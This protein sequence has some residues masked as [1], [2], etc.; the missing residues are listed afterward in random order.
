MLKSS[1]AGVFRSHRQIGE[2]ILAGQEFGR[3]DGQPISA[4]LSCIIRGLLMPGTWVPAGTK[5]GLPIPGRREYCYTISD[6]A[7]AIAGG[8]LEALLFL[9]RG[10][11]R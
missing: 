11:N 1:R 4:Q 5:L 8:V 10:M 6:K 7:R 3:I 2:S 9:S